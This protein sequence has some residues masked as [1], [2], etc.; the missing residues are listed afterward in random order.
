MRSLI[1]VGTAVASCW[2]ANPVFDVEGYGE[3]YYFS[4]SGNR[5]DTV[6]RFT[7]EP[8][9][10]FSDVVTVHAHIGF[11]HPAEDGTWA[12]AELEA[13]SL[14][15]KLDDKTLFSFGKM[16]MPIGMYNLYHE[17]IYFLTIEPSRV[18]NLIIPTEWHETA[19][20]LSRSIGNLTLTGGAMTPMDGRKLEY[21]SWIHE[22]KES[23]LTG[24]KRP[25]WLVRADYGTIETALIG[26]SAVT[27]P[28]I[29]CDAQAT[30]VEAHASVRLENGWEG[31]ALAAKGWIDDVASL[32]ALTNQKIAGHAQGASLTVGYDVGR[33]VDLSKRQVVA[34]AHSEYA[35]PASSL[36]PNTLGGTAHSGGINWFITPSVVAKTEFV[37]SNHEGDRL[38]I[39]LGF[40]Y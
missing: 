31:S 15:A 18:E 7:V 14:D 34:F 23:Y 20:L 13:L 38:G 36:N 39:G 26:A 25:G 2:A 37:H 3:S 5:S 4:Q 33:L 30:L 10:N 28:M 27:V 32:N 19:A 21:S 9:V 6:A 11:E 40:V 29:G 1:I 35:M 8:S 22:G 16:H 17:P 12:E 24:G